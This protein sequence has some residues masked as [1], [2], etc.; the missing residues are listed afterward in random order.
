MEKHKHFYIMTIVVLLLM[1]AFASSFYL[2]Y[3]NNIFSKEKKET[4]VELDVMSEEV[5]SLYDKI[6]Y[7]LN[8]YCGVNDYYTNKKVVA[9]DISNETAFELVL[10]QLHEKGL[11]NIISGG[12][13]RKEAV[14]E[15][16]LELFGSDYTFQHQTYQTCPIFTYDSITETYTSG[17]PAC[18]GMCGAY[19]LKRV[20]KAIQKNDTIS[21]FVRVLFADT[22]SDNGLVAYYRDYNKTDLIYDLERD[23]HG[24]VLNNEENLSKGSLYQLDF[25]LEEGNY[26]FVSSTPVKETVQ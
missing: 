8:L 17:D 1:M 13:F 21:L 14:D 23:E 6:S 19:P 24:V 4:E 9:S 7:G 2:M 12:S 26:V 3:D 11:Y 20:E 5:T 16:L 25:V 15:V 18:G 22:S 10:T